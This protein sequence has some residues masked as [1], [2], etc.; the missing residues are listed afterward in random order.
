MLPSSW[1][2]GGQCTQTTDCNFILIKTLVVFT[3]IFWCSFHFWSSR[4]SDCTWVKVSSW[5]WSGKQRLEFR[6]LYKIKTADWFHR[7]L[8]RN[9]QTKR[10]KSYVIV[11]HN[12]PRHLLKPNSRCDSLRLLGDEGSAAET[13]F[14]ALKIKSFQHQWGKFLWH[15]APHK[16][17]IYFRRITPCQPSSSL[18]LRKFP[19]ERESFRFQIHPSGIETTSF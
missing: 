11:S 6:F 1:C 15:W 16:P 3:N 13:K 2:R 4:L 12:F 18:S 7:A 10:E 19:S 17:T 9:L 8:H 14:A 5:T